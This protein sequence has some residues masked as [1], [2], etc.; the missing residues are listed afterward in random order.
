MMGRLKLSKVVSGQAVRCSVQ[1]QV[2]SGSDFA[3]RPSSW[4]FEKG[5]ERGNG[6]SE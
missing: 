4:R 5:V 1:F 6:I 2:V 3:F